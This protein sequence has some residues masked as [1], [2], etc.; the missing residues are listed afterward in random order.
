MNRYRVIQARIDF[1]RK[2][3]NQNPALVWIQNQT[4]ERK[5]SKTKGEPFIEAD[6]RNQVKLGEKT[7]LKPKLTMKTMTR[8]MNMD[9][10]RSMKT[11]LRLAVT[12]HKIK[13]RPD[14]EQR[15]TEETQK[16]NEW[17]RNTWGNTAER[18]R[19]AKLNTLNMEHKTLQNKTGTRKDRTHDNTEH[20]AMKHMTYW[21]DTENQE[22][23]HRQRRIEET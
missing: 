14:A 11:I 12:W 2:I 18:H 4:R 3:Y 9:L 10:N 8:N 7:K 5:W 16:G 15:E 13:R 20:T 23:L 6:N 22:N 21:G 19:E 17:S 1:N